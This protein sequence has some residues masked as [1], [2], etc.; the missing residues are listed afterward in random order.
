MQHRPCHLS[1]VGCGG[2][3]ADSCALCPFDAQGNFYGAGWCNG[4]CH[5]RTLTVAQRAQAEGALD[6]FKST[7]SRKAP[8][9]RAP[10]PEGVCVG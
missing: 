2:H 1:G 3:R 8:T 6:Q 10:A 4:Q 9:S 5:W 7:R